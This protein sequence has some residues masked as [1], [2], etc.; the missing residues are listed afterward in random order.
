MSA[1]CRVMSC[2][3]KA[4]LSRRNVAEPRQRSSL[5]AGRIAQGCRP[6]PMGGNM[7]YQGAVPMTF[8]PALDLA[9]LAYFVVAWIGYAVAVEWRQQH[10]GSLNARIHRYRE[11]WMRRA[12]SPAARLVDMQIM[13]SLPNGTAFL[14]SPSLRPG[15]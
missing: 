12:L 14:P 3:I 11:V 13:G 15:V 10:H 7:P 6:S 2:A 1:T 4:L 9:A 5:Q 8:L